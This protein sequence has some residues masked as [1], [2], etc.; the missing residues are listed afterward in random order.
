MVTVVWSVL[1]LW[2]TLQSRSSLA[3]STCLM[4]GG[5]KHL[6]TL[7]V[8]L[9]LTAERMTVLRKAMSQSQCQGLPERSTEARFAQGSREEEM[10][11][12]ALSLRSSIL[13]L[14]TGPKA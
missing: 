10:E 14:G 3:M 12:R 6:T 5:L 8:S 4:L 13:R 11:D 2:M 1:G 7:T 9:L